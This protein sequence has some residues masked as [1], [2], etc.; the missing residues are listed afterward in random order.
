MMMIPIHVIAFFLAIMMVPEDVKQ[1]TFAVHGKEIQWTRQETGWHA[2][3]LPRDDWGT[4]SVKGTEVTISGEG[5][6]MKT[7]IS[8]Y[9]TLPGDLDWQK[10]AEI[11]V[12]LKSL[13]GPVQIQRED[14]KIVL[15]QAKGGLFEKPVTITWKKSP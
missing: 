2:V 9:L 15:S 14:G 12:A 10:A 6:E 8:R 13:G 7:N 11:Q 4:Y 3:E 1:F 5:R